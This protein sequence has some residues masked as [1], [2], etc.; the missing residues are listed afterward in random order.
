MKTTFLIL[1]STIFVLGALS[2]EA[3]SKITRTPDAT[4]SSAQSSNNPVTSSWANG[5]TSGS[6]SHFAQLEM[7]K[8]LPAAPAIGFM[9]LALFIL[10]LRL[11]AIRHAH[12]LAQHERHS[13]DGREQMFRSLHEERSSRH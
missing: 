12:S 4:F 8:T 9:L 6:T 5:L 1:I 11:V 13:A 3:S 2:A 7:A 10:A